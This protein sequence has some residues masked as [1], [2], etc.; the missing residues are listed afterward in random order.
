M[1]YSYKDTDYADKLL[2]SREELE[3]AYQ[4]YQ[5]RLSLQ[6]HEVEIETRQAA[7]PPVFL[8]SLPD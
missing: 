7:T 2:P 3:A 1:Y 5:T 4:E 8:M 6:L